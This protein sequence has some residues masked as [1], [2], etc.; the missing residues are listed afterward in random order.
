[1]KLLQGLS[2]FFTHPRSIQRLSGRPRLSC[3]RRASCN[4]QA[5]N[6]FPCLSFSRL[7]QPSPASLG[8]SGPYAVLLELSKFAEPSGLARKHGLEFLEPLTLLL[9]RSVSLAPQFP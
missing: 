2:H 6:R 1:M 7:L 5:E 9:R 8:G 3:S 4:S